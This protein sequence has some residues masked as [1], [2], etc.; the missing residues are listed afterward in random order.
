MNPT[1]FFPIAILFI[2]FIIFSCKDNET[3]ANDDDAN[4]VPYG[5]ITDT[6]GCKSFF[7][8]TRNIPK[9]NECVKVNY[10][11]QDEILQLIHVNAGFNCCPGV[12]SAEI[13]IED[14]VISFFEKQSQAG[15][16]CN[17]LYDVE[18]ELRNVEPGEYEFIIVGPL[19]DG[20]SKKSLE[21]KIDISEG[22]G[23]FCL[24]RN[25]YPWVE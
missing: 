7:D 18:Y 14:G 20:E 16:R 9:T 19:T 17:C 5:I 3:T 6:S 11:S 1:K 21:C 10:S 2:A 23:E 4:G 15:C 13:N 24:E 25:F 8:T 12:I 22:T